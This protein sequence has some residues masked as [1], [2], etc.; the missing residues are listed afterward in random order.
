[1]NEIKYTNPEAMKIA[2][3]YDNTIEVAFHKITH[4]YYINGKPA[5]R[6]VTKILSDGLGKG[7][8][9]INWMVRTAVDNSVDRVIGAL[10]AGQTI[11]DIFL[12]GLRQVAK[13]EPEKVRD[14]A[15][16]EGTQVHKILE[17]WINWG[18]YGNEFGFTVTQE[19]AD[20]LLEMLSDRSEQLH[21]SIRQ[22]MDWLIK[23]KTVI[24]ASEQLVYSKKYDIPGM[25]D[26]EISFVGEKDRHIG[27][28]KIRSGVYEETRLQTA[29]YQ[30]ARTEESGIKFGNRYIFNIVRKDN[31]DGRGAQFTG[32]FK[33]K[34][35]NNFKAD[36][37]IFT[38]L[39]EIVEWREWCKQHDK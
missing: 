34:E 16:D 5:A 11:D 23:K 3:L 15:A 35:Y 38:R 20:K 25:L 32:D 24:H 7:D 1:M 30:A 22:M 13:A 10:K 4:R 18:L 12:A 6:S 37:K 36:L 33:I 9:L 26:A 28:F 21:M 29:I 19:H 31:K 2:R 8:A 17:D 39:Q 14:E 27:D